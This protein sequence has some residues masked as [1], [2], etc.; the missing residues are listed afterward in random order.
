MNQTP[1]EAWV[2]YED[3]FGRQ[4]GPFAFTKD[5]TVEQEA[6]DYAAKCVNPCKVTKLPFKANKEF[7]PEYFNEIEFKK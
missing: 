6:R 1:T 3:I 5:F 4:T 2:V 7:Y